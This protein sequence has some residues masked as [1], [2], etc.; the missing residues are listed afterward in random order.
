METGRKTSKKPNDMQ[1]FHYIIRTLLHSKGSN[2]LKVVSL[3]LGLA[4]SILLFSRVAFEQSYD[5][6][7][8]DYDRLYQVWMQYTVKG[9]KLDWQQQN[10][11]P[12]AGAILESFPEQVES[13]TCINRW[14]ASDPLYYGNTRFDEPKI[15]AD[16][17]FF[18]T[19]GIEVLSGNPVQDLQQPYVIYLSETLARRMFGG[20]DPIG[21]VISYNYQ[22]D[23]TVRGTYTDL[24]DNT[25]VKADAVISL[26]PSWAAEVANYSWYGGDSYPQYVRLKQ[27]A[28]AEAVNQRMEALIDKHLQLPPEFKAQMGLAAKIAPL[29]DTYRDYED[30]QRSK[31]ILLVMG[32]AILFI[33]ALNYALISISSLSRRAKAVGVQKCSGASGAGI[34]GMFL[35]ETA[36]I[37]I[38]SLCV[39]VFLLFAFQDFV[40]DT[41]GTRLHNLL[42]WQRAWVP[43]LTVLLLFVVGGVLPGHLFARIPVTQV[44]RRYTE[45][46]KGWKRSLLF[47]QFAGV[48]FICGVMMMVTAQYNYVMNKDMGFSVKNVAT[49]YL[50]F[51]KENGE[52]ARQFFLG[53]PYVEAVSNSLWGDPLDGYSGSM[54]GDETGQPLFSSRI[55]YIAEDYLSFMGMTLKQGRAPRER[56]EAVVNETFAD[57]MHW[58]DE[59]LGRRVDAKLDDQPVTIVGLVKDFNIGGCYSEPLP[60]IAGY[61]PR[62]SSNLLIKLKEPFGDNLLKLQ[63]A[64]AEAFPGRTIDIYSMQQQA[65]NLYNPVRVLRNA[66][67]VAAIVMFFIMLMGL[68]GYTADEVQRRSKEIAIRKVNGAEAGGILELL[69]RDILWVALPAVLIGVGAS[70]YVNG[71][72][73]DMFSVTVPGGWAVYVLVALVNLLVIL[74]CVLW[75]TW[76]IANENPV[77]SLKNE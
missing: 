27:G 56:Y 63:Q 62:F 13:A 75:R 52:A 77:L 1:S 65:E 41:A 36:L 28:D 47:V 2:L 39:M 74:A 73:L 10:L 8:K 4:M 71:L 35:T 15:C 50:P 76:H 45:G 21:K 22:Y 17:L 11:G 33:A 18:Q 59:V 51:D 67:V 12:L 34:F 49:T 54:I 46:K 32:F 72:W 68:L 14:M 61:A 57:R 64:T 55:D 58:G 37:I 26:P 23:L 24:P 20:E 31:V 60:Y 48:A 66:M 6:C 69:G 43:A 5:T 19:M 53:L 16:S 25:T 30:V 40:E 70:A 7:F 42:T 3:G 29:R 44:F 38:W 9:E